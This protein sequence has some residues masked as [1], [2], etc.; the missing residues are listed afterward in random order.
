[1]PRLKVYDLATSSWLYAGGVDPVALATDAAFTSRFAQRTK[2]V[3]A[4]AGTGTAGDWYYD[5]TNKRSYQSDGGGWVIMSEPTQTYAPVLNQS[6]V[7]TTTVNYGVYKRSDGW[8]KGAFRL[9]I[10]AAGVAGV[11]IYAS[12]PIAEAYASGLPEGAFWY[13][14]SG[15]MRYSGS[16]YLSTQNIYGQSD[17]VSSF[18]GSLPNF[19]VASGDLYM[20]SF[21]YQMLTRYL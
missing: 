13:Q 11:S 19:A 1:M 20:A 18:I 9:A 4:P 21:E 5:T 6:G 16:I 10:T 8:V 17:G 14:T 2:G 15:G 12:V 7:R 3:G